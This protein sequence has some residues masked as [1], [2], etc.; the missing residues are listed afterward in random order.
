M[1]AITEIPKAVELEQA[2]LAAVIIDWE[3][4][5]K[6]RP[7]LNADDF[8]DNAHKAIF[9]AFFCKLRR[10][11]HTFCLYFAGKT[12]FSRDFDDQFF[13]DPFELRCLNST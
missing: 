6:V 10:I 3:S 7:M 13:L 11:V 8:Y 1:T 12:R 5:Y 9:A 4:I 2:V